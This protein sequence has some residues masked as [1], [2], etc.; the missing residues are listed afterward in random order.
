MRTETPLT[1]TTTNQHNTGNEERAVPSPALRFASAPLKLWPPQRHIVT[2]EPERTAALNKARMIYA[3]GDQQAKCLCTSCL[4]ELLVTALREELVF[5]NLPD[6]YDWSEKVTEFY[7]VTEPFTATEIE[8]LDTDDEEHI[9]RTYPI[10]V[11]EIKKEIE[12]RYLNGALADGR[13]RGMLCNRR[14]S[15]LINVLCARA[16]A[17]FGL[18][19]R[20]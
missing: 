14:S 2:E 10:M 17:F 8:L 16:S 7:A 6:T 9:R 18:Q 1:E 5:S 11:Q 4:C 3:T 19:S 13:V 15:S 20:R 12:S